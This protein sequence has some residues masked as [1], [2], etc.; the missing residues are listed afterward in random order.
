MPK[1]D[2]KIHLRTRYWVNH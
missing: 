1:K 2:S